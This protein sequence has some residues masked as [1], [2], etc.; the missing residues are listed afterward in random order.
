MLSKVTSKEF[1]VLL[2]SIV[3]R[4]HLTKA[5][6]NDVLQLLQY[7]LP[8]GNKLPTSN[9]LLEKSLNVDF[10]KADKMY[11]C[12]ICEGPLFNDDEEQETCVDCNFVSSKKELDKSDRYFFLLDIR[13]VL[14][15]SLE[16]PSN[17]DEVVKNLMQRDQQVAASD[18]VSDVKDGECYRNLGILLQHVH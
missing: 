10:E 12:S 2:Y 6:T 7:A 18:V 11:Y 9:Y 14:R 1:I 17:G 15:F 8:P 3:F 4:H 5:C 16:I 13:E